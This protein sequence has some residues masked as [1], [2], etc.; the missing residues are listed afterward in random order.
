MRKYACRLRRIEDASSALPP[1]VIGAVALWS[2]LS[3]AII[4][5]TAAQVSGPEIPC[6]SRI[7]QR[8]GITA[9]AT[10]R[11]VPR[12]W[13]DRAR[14]DTEV[15]PPIAVLVLIVRPRRARPNAPSPRPVHASGHAVGA[16]STSLRVVVGTRA[17]LVGYSVAVG[18]VARVTGIRSARA[19]RASARSPI[20]DPTGRDACLRSVR[21]WTR[22]RGSVQTLGFIG[23]RRRIRIFGAR[24]RIAGIREPRQSAPS[25]G[26]V[27]EFAPPTR[28]SRARRPVCQRSRTPDRGR[29]L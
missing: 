25:P 12:R 19:C 22:T 13:R 5:E 28:T 20:G 24:T 10:S 23:D 27:W 18:V 4:V 11:H 16:L 17:P 26:T 2:G 14:R 6:L 29:D 7:G 21:A 1:A 15:A 9:I 8:I 3:I